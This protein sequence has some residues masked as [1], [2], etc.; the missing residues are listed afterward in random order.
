MRIE[1]KPANEQKSQQ[2]HGDLDCPRGISSGQSQPLFPKHNSLF[3]YSLDSLESLLLQNRLCWQ[4]EHTHVRCC[5]SDAAT[6]HGHSIA[7]ERHTD[8]DGFRRYSHNWSGITC[9]AREQ[10]RTW[11]AAWTENH[12]STVLRHRRGLKADEFSNLHLF[13][14]PSFIF[15]SFTSEPSGKLLGLDI[16][17]CGVCFLCDDFLPS[18]PDLST[19]LKVSRGCF[20]LL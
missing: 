20:L 6:T 17:I 8:N 5:N 1:K 2:M 3:L 15:L 7:T 9:C 12:E 13:L 10:R 14:S 11:D 19:L 18:L 16:F 4:I